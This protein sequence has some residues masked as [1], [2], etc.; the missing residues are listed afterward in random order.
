MERKKKYGALI[1]KTSIKDVDSS[2]HIEI[3]NMCNNTNV[4][5]DL[6]PSFKESMINDNILD[7]TKEIAEFAIDSFLEDGG[8]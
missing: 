7:T 4:L 1:I 3:D 5:T 8:F 6:I 2:K